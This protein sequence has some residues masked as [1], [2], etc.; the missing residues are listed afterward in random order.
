[1]KNA[2]CQTQ[3]TEKRMAKKSRIGQATD[4]VRTVAGKALGAAAAAATAVVVDSVTAALT[5]GG[6]TP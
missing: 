6:D 1:M 4:E 3:T 2:A 5:H